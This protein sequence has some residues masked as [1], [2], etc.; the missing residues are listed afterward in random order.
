MKNGVDFFQDILFLFDA[1]EHKTQN[2][3][4]LTTHSTLL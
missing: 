3:K 4:Y 2:S 1:K